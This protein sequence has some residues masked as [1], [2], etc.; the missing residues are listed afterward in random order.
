M[1]LRESGR[2]CF[3]S[4]IDL[5]ECRFSVKEDAVTLFMPLSYYDLMCNKEKEIN[6]ISSELVEEFGVVSV[7]FKPWHGLA[8]QELLC[9]NKTHITQLTRAVLSRSNL[10]WDKEGVRLVVAKSMYN[11]ALGSFVKNQI[12]A[13]VEEVSGFKLEIF[14]Q[15]GKR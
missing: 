5:S 2:K 13:E 4:G 3:Y 14:I 12:K 9:I 8:S 6:I 1:K 11:N 15:A 10:F 7:E